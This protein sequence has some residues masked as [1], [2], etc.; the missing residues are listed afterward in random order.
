L[1]REDKDLY[2]QAMQQEIEDLINSNT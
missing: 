2:L 1:L